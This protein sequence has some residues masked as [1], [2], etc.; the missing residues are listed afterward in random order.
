LSE[1]SKRDNAGVGKF[2]ERGITG[3]SELPKRLNDQKV[4]KVE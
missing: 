4:W 2:P 1:I 3:V